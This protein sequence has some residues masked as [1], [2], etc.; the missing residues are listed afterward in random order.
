MQATKCGDY[1]AKTAKEIELGTDGITWSCTDGLN[2]GSVCNKS[3]A[4]GHYVS[5][6]HGERLDGFRVS[7]TSSR[8]NKFSEI[9]L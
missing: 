8:L 9:F 2:G 5:D 7:E 4:A 1:P 3:C 6:N